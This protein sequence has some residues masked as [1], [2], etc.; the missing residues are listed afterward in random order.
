MKT[1]TTAAAGLSVMLLLAACGAREITDIPPMVQLQRIQIESNHVRL[2]LRIDNANSIAVS[3]GR[4]SFQLQLEGQPFASHDSAVQL[5]I[6]A[7]NAEVVP[8]NVTPGDG[9]MQRLRALVRSDARELR[10]SMQG[11]LKLDQSLESTFETRGRCFAVPG[12]QQM[13]RCT[14]SAAEGP[15]SREGRQRRR[16]DFGA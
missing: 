4:L 1:I 10:W 14:G 15:E 7:N 16:T 12:Q 6:V 8:I 5:D 9:D 11:K 13:L 3:G 2:A